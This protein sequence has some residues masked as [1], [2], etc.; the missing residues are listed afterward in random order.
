MA[1]EPELGFKEVKTA[2]K[3]AAVFDELGL[4]YQTGLALTGVKARL[5]GA[6]AGPTLA[7]LGELDAIGCPD[8]PQADPQTG[9]A[10]AC[11][12]NLQQAA[13]LGAAYG[14]KLSGVMSELAG[15]VVF[16][17]VPAE[18]Y[19][20]LEYRR[21]LIAEGK[22]HF[23]SGKGELIY[24]GEFEDIDLAMQI[25]A[26]KNCPLPT[27]AIGQSSN[28][29]IGKTIQYVGKTAHAADAPDQGIN[30]LNAAMLGLMGINALRE[31]FREQDVIR[32]HPIITKGGDLV[33]SVPADVRIETYVRAKTMQAIEATH[34]KVD[35]AL[36]AGG[37]A[38][39]AKTIINTLPGQLPLVCNES[40]NALFTA[41]A[42]LVNPQVEIID[43]GHF[44]ASTDMGDVSHLMPVI[45][46][47]IG[48]TDGLLH[49]KDFCVTDYA[50]A[51][52]LP[53]K[54]FAL[55]AI[56]LL[57]QKAA[58]AKE[59]VAS[60]KPVLTREE[61]IEKLEGYFSK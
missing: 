56:D 58:V 4:E 36:K 46:P 59:I 50:S 2:A 25:H 32:V 35:A 48:G 26:Q 39:G 13:M 23:L 37:D 60:S 27:V 43:A 19:V 57:A 6:Q 61:Y 53:A 5:D 21:R 34:G 9:A 12:H 24:R 54:T 8:S 11:G 7:I 14:L 1:R 51:V 16:F 55:M 10:H 30:A 49:T 40:M 38:V 31:T 28:G 52:L 20:E 22:I 18:E 3:V 17:A 42:R 44:G 15:S 29:F 41:N 45:H 47:F 33:N